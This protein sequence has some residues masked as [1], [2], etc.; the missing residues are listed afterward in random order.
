MN[1]DPADTH[2]DLEDLI[3]AAADQGAPEHLARCEQCQRELNRWNLVACG[4]RA[5]AAGAPQAARPARPRRT[6]RR[7]PARYW[8]RAMLVA[9]SAAAAL[10]LLVGLGA[11][12]GLVHVHFSSPG[13]GTGTGTVLTTVLGCSQLEQ[14]GGVLEQVNGS[15]LIIKTASGQPV[16]VTTTATTFVSMTGNLLRDITDGA[17][18][19]VRGSQSDGTI[20]ATLVTVGQPFRAVNPPGMTPVQGTVADASTAG[21]TLVTS[22]G[23]RIPVTTSSE[24]L[25]VV[26]HARLGQ[27]QVGAA[28]IALVQAGPDGTLPARAVAMISQFRSGA[29]VHVS[30]KDCSSSSIQEALAMVSALPVS[31]GA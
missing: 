17:S 24:T 3:A 27:L 22:G 21:F 20:R 2:L 18:V 9:G 6:G 30:V 16:T 26:V 28:V 5:L 13:R 25:V 4:V 10:V 23:T 7:A 15:S 12:A 14:A 11:A 8:R 29:R 1:A 19:R 31:A